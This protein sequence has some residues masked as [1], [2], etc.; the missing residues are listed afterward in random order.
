M[1]GD[2]I[3]KPAIVVT[4]EQSPYLRDLRL[5]SNTV[6]HTVE[7]LGDIFLSGIAGHIH[8]KIFI[9]GWATPC[10]SQGSHIGV[11]NI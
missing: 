10:H 2:G 11:V 6:S 1:P 9:Q 8:E 3:N 7:L 5:D 4:I